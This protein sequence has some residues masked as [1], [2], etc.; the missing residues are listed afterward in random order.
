MLDPLAFV[1]PPPVLANVGARQ[2]LTDESL[3]M[4]GLVRVLA[5]TDFGWSLGLVGEDQASKLAKLTGDLRR[6]I[7]RAGD[8]KR[9]A[10]GFSYL[11]AEPAIAWTRACRDPLYPVMRESIETFGQRWLS[12]RRSLTGVPYHYVS[13]G[14]GDGQK[15]A[16]ILQDLRINNSR[17]CYV[18]V[19]MS[20]EM[21]R[22]GAHDLLHQ[23]KIVR[24]RILPV[25]LDFS[26][27]SNVLELRLLLDRLFGDEP[28]LLSV[29]GNTVANF[30][31][32]TELLRMLGQLLLRPQDRLVLEVATTP[33]VDGELAQEAADEY[34]RSRA[35]REFVT[36]ALMH[37]TDLRIDMDSVLFHGTAE[38]DRAVL[39]KVTYQNQT[40]RTIRMVLPD[41]TDIPFRSSDTIRL[42][43][44]RKYSKGGLDG[45]L[46][47]SDLVKL[48][49]TQSNLA[50]SRGGPGFGMDL[51]VL[52]SSGGEPGAGLCQPNGAVADE[53][54]A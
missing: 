32:D 50:T 10:S 54:W 23:M 33:S 48:H 51:L 14:P 7:S 20:A 22:L 42:Y 26:G 1:K 49:G 15:D 38:Q 52:A 19:D 44:S 29:L 43:V 46:A 35:F 45:L 47:D 40:G 4:T 30:D 28:V 24:D 21:L 41:R 34:G 39:V 6:G 17:L 36:S 25:Q 37:Y 3:V 9:I 53:I 18:A 12:I 13:L 11:G 16:I 8:G 31:N 2:C 5:E 27:R